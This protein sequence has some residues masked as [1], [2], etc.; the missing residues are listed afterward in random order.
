[1]SGEYTIRPL[2]E[3]VEDQT[4]NADEKALECLTNVGELNSKDLARPEYLSAATTFALLSITE[5][6]STS[7][8]GLGLA[9]TLARIS[10]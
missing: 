7:A 4:M 10:R 3:I 5:A 8:T 6:L 2:H 9:D 1:M